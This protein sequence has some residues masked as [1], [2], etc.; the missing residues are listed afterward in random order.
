MTPKSSDTTIYLT[1][2]EAD[3]IRKTATEHLKKCSDLAGH[4]REPRDAKAAISQATGAALM[5]DMGTMTLAH[6]QPITPPLLI[7]SQPYPPSLIPIS[8]LRPIKISEL[9]LSTHHRGRQLAVKRMSPVVTLSTRSWTMVQ[10]D[11]GEIERLEIALHSTGPGGR[12][13]LESARSFVL[14][15]PYFTLTPD[16]EPTLRID[17][18]SDLLTITAPTNKAPASD[19]ANTQLTTTVSPPVKAKSVNATSVGGRTEVRETATMGRGLFVVGQVVKRG[20]VV[21]GEKAFCAVSGVGKTAVTW[22]GRDG[23]VRVAA[24]GLER[25]V[26]KKL[27]GNPGEI[28]Q[29]MGLFGDWE[30]AG[31]RV[32][33]AGD[34]PVVDVFRVQ[35]I[36]ARNAFGMGEG[37]SAGLWIRAAYINH[38]CVPNAERELV[39][40]LMIVRATRDIA[41]GEQIFHSYDQSADYEARQKVLITTWGFEC[42]C[43]LCVVEKGDEPAV[44]ETRREL[45]KEADE[46]VRVARWPAGRLAIV[47]GRRLAKKIQETYGEERYR[48]LPRLATR[49]IQAWL[50]KAAASS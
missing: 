3:R 40:D 19:P 34:G 27:L 28:G 11:A 5:A 8:E 31:E 2:Q 4:A 47:K 25:A 38:S 9:Q 26:V 18:P 43:A 1:E 45:A 36:V 49:G 21:M 42:G 48:G 37:G 24:V 17:H 7:V 13:M 32:V 46:F 29:V 16:G 44:R 6:P 14:K 41:V 30:G 33:E 20:E 35:D 15:E 12:D 50:A 22:D 10:D 39:G 23:R